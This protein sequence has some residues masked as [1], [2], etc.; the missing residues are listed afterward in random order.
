MLRVHGAKLGELESLVAEGLALLPT[1]SNV[2]YIFC[3]LSAAG[4]A[5]AQNPTSLW[6]DLGAIPTRTPRNISKVLTSP[7]H[8]KT[9]WEAIVILGGRQSALFEGA[10][11]IIIV[12]SDR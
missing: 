4:D 7:V 6:R 2:S 9:A 11:H 10:P 5:S 12:F 1:D 3:R 8:R